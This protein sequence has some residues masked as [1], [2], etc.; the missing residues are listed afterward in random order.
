MADQIKIVI[1]IALVIANSIECEAEKSVKY[2]QYKLV[3]MFTS[4]IKDQKTI[5]DFLTPRVDFW[6]SPHTN[7]TVDFMI[8]PIEYH[9]VTGYLQHQ[10]ISYKTIM[11]DVQRA[12]DA[13]LNEVAED[14]IVDKISERFSSS[15][16]RRQGGNPFLNFFSFLMKSFSMDEVPQTVRRPRKIQSNSQANFL[17]KDHSMDW[18]SY[19]RL[20]DIYDYLHYLQRHYPNVAEVIEIGKSVQERPMFV[21]KIGSKK[22]T[23]KPA[24]FIEAGIHARE[25]ISP[26]TAT[27]IIKQLVERSDQNQD[28]L[29]F[30]DIYIIPVTNPD[31]Y[32]YTFTSDRLWRKNRRKNLGLGSLLLAMCDGVDLN[33]NFGHK[34]YQR[35]EKHSRNSGTQEQCAGTYSGTGP[36]SEPETDNIRNFVSSIQ[37]NLVSYVSLHSY[38]QKILYPWS[39]TSARIEDWYDLQQMGEIMAKEIRKSSGDYYLVGRESSGQYQTIGGSGDWARGAMGIKWVFLFELPPG[40]FPNGP[41]GFMLPARGIKPTAKSIF[42]AFRKMAVEVSHRIL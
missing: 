6:T 14:S 18:S 3:R 28:L 9:K 41:A 10:R 4:G 19:H 29:D 1:L 21:L 38:G 13:N 15:F 5:Y 16:L 25:W 35:A 42:Q 22:S 27:Y 34:W 23:Y 8:S 7:G 40:K 11:R 26:A 20:N 31:G 39:Y 33:R 24:I 32:E 12:I 17:G 2:D 37:E 30:Y 36:F